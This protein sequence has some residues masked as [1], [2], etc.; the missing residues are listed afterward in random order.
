MPT[1]QDI[2]LVF[3]GDT[4]VL[5]LTVFQEDGVTPYDLTGHAIWMTAKRNKDDAD[6]DAVFQ[7]STTS[8]AITIT[9]AAGGV[10]QIVPP[11]T[12]TSGLTAD[13]KLFYDV[14]VRNLAGTRTHTTTYGRL[15]VRRDVTRA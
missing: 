6:L 2:E 5:G 8:G 1:E 10:A 13:E 14:Q 15:T 9:N 7:V 12:A 3:R 11:T 4:P